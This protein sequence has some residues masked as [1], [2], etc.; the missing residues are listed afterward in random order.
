MIS[1][2]DV[3]L[4]H[5]LQVS[6]TRHGSDPDTQSRFPYSRLPCRTFK[7]WLSLKIVC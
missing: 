1:N 3:S 2:I 7:A 6:S 4:E 5:V